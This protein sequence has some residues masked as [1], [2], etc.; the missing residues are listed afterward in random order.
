ML[1]TSLL[2]LLLLTLSGVLL[3]AHRREWWAA[4]AVPAGDDAAGRFARRRRT[5]R[6]TATA[7]IGVA[8]ALVGVWP[9]VPR[10]PIWVLGYAAALA[11]VALVVFALALIDA[12]ASSR[13]YRDASRRALESQLEELQRIASRGD[14]DP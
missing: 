8:G 5:R 6:T 12:A 1:A 11:S 13:Y 14:G 10:L 7:L 2:S 3:D 9:I 4:C